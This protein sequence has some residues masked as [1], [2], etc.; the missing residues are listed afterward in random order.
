[1]DTLAFWLPLLLL[2]ISALLGTAMKRKA[3]DHCLKKFEGCNIILPSGEE[4]WER[5]ISHVFAQGLELVY[6]KPV[7]SELGQIS[8]HV[9]HPAEVGKI[10]Y[11]I[12]PA[13]DADTRSGQKWKKELERIRT[14]NFFDITLRSLLNF[15]NMLRDAFGQA[16]QAVV[17]AMSKD[18]TLSKIKNAD[19]RVN[20]LHSGLVE[21]VPNAWEPVLEKYRG[22]V[23]V[24]ERKTATGMVQESGILEDYSAKYLLVREV[25]IQDPKLQ[26]FLNNASGKVKKAHDVLYNRSVSMIRHRVVSV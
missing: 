12:R 19:K 24:V 11:F 10:P 23:I 25:E 4:S 9:L 18:T 17:G 6:E 15:Y 1:M 3:R 21:L 5:G 26:D 22:S 20:E 2:F 13:P 14:P 7:K 16:S 8:S